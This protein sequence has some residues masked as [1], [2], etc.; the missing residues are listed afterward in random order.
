MYT[1]LIGGLSRGEA[2]LPPLM[3]NFL[4]K[5]FIL[6]APKIIYQMS[7]G[8]NIGFDPAAGASRR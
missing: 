8:Q 6:K 2:L 3:A 1:G 7:F 4:T 5:I